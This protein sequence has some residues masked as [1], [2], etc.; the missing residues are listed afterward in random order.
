LRWK[1]EEDTSSL[2]FSGDDEELL[3]LTAKKW[4]LERD[5]SKL[6]RIQLHIDRVQ[7]AKGKHEQE[8][9]AITI[10]YVSRLASGSN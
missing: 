9:L 1:S 5:A 10:E 4:K 3:M 7:K 2:S 6:A 8:I